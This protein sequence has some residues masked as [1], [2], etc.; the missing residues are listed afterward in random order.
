MKPYKFEIPADLFNHLLEIIKD[1][2][3]P[4]QSD[5]AGNIKE[6]YNLKKYCY[7]L[8]DFILQKINESEDMNGFLQQMDFVAPNKQSL[9]LTNLWVNFQKK[10]EFNP[11]HNHSG[12]FSF[13]L[14]MQIPFDMEEELQVAPGRGNKDIPG[15]LQFLSLDSSAKSGISE[16]SFPIDRAWEATGL[17]FPATLNHLVYP[18]YSSDD[19]RIT[20]SGNVTFNNEM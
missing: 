5:L 9:K 13:V 3:V 8:N 7:L 6:E 14:F 16:N 1:K 15:H 10:Y 11:F 18:F 19:Y 20:I 4:Y 2:S 12:L 17:L